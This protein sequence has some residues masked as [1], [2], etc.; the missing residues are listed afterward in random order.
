MFDRLKS[1]FKMPEPAGPPEEIKSYTPADQ[2]IARDNVTVNGESWKI[3]IDGESSVKLFELPVVSGIENC[4]LTYRAQMKAENLSGKAY[5]EMWCRLPGRGEFFSKGLKNPL[6]GTT[7][8]TEHE[9]PF[10]LKK[11]Q[12]PDLL[13]L[14][15]FGKGQGTVHIKDIK[16]LKTPFK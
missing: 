2:T 5:L 14:N 9:V 4:M 11:G 13:K 8:W 6:T 3:N 7:G 10:Y 1:L 12:Q 15:V 16:V